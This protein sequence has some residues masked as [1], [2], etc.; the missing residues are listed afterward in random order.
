MTDL[1]LIA[2]QIV[3]KATKADIMLTC[4]NPAQAAWLQL[5]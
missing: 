5:H 3:T 1:A 2:E 4:A